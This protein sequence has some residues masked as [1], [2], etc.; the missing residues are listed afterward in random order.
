MEAQ[1]ARAD[2]GDLS[3]ALFN[4]RAC[5]FSASRKAV[6]ALLAQACLKC[7]HAEFY[8]SEH[9]TWIGRSLSGSATQEVMAEGA[10]VSICMNLAGSELSNRG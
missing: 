3:H 8:W 2:P 6:P 7:M 4:G 5:G 10:I 1:V 9:G